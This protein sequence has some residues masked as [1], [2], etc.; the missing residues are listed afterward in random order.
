MARGVAA[1][2]GA[3]AGAAGA[4]RLL[5]VPGGGLRLATG[6]VER[7]AG[8]FNARA[9]LAVVWADPGRATAARGRGSVFHS[10]GGVRSGGA[11]GGGDLLRGAGAGADVAPAAELCGV[12]VGGAGVDAG[13]A[14]ASGVAAGGRRAVFAAALSG[15]GVPD[16]L[17]AGGMGRAIAVAVAGAG[18]ALAGGMHCAGVLAG[19]GIGNRVMGGESSPPAPLRARRGG[20]ADGFQA[21]EWVSDA[22]GGA[23]TGERPAALAGDLQPFCDQALA[24]FGGGDVGAG[25]RAGAGQLR[26]GDDEDSVLIRPFNDHGVVCLIHSIS[27]LLAALNPGL[28]RW[29]SPGASALGSLEDR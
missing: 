14:A 3:G 17:R 20:A 26:D 28:D 24:L 4:G 13:D 23:R 8:V 25:V 1:A 9:G 29:L 18:G 19:D 2:G 11:G 6:G 7:G 27:P 21:R 10:A 5:A 16:L 22:G 15:G 12:R